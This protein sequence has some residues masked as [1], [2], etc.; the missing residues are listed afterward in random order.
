MNLSLSFIIP[1][2]NDANTIKKT[3]LAADAVGKKIKAN[4]EIIVIN[5][6]SIDNTQAEINKIS[7]KLK[8]LKIYFHKKNKGYGETI[9]ELYY[10]AN[11]SWI[12]S[13]P[14]DL[15]ID[16]KEVLKLIPFIDEYDMIIGKRINRSDTFLRRSQSR[17]YNS[18]LR[19]LF[20]LRLSDV[21]SVRLLKSGVLKKIRLES[22]SAFVDAELAIKM[23]RNNFKTIEAPIT[24]RSRDAEGGGGGSMKIILPTITELIIFYLFG[25]NESTY[26]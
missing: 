19:I 3:V 26:L 24:H 1:A 14:G 13:I 16:A 22:K 12:F 4:Y 18:L 10:A 6:A 8:N 23:Q 5:D 2:Y 21:N 7:P 17:I 25:K 11:K 15:Q 9:K 20:N